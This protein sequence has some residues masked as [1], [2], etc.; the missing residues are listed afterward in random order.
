V[1]MAA[2]DIFGIVES[3]SRTRRF[4]RSAKINRLVT[5]PIPK[6][7]PVAKRKVA[8]GRGQTEAESGAG[9]F[10]GI[11]VQNR[12]YIIAASSELSRKPYAE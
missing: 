11:Y 1:D 4:A 6:D 2:Q 7:A 8:M 3:R 10:P 12:W 5:D 9:E